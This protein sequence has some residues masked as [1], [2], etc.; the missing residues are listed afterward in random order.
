MAGHSRRFNPNLELLRQLIGRGH[1]GDVEQISAALGGR[2][3][4]WPQRTDFRRSRSLAGGG[5]LMDL[6]IHLIDLA[7]WLVDREASVE[8]YEASDVLSWGVE[9]D[10]EVTLRF[11][12]GAHAL[13]AC[14]YTH[15]L[16]RTLRVRGSHGWAETSVD[17]LPTVTFFSRRARV[18]QQR[19][20]QSFMIP[21]ADPYVRQLN[22]FVAAIIDEQPFSVDLDHV[23]AG[24]RVIQECYRVAQAA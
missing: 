15:G 6:G 8:R 19:G 11:D 24:L 9:S 4:A 20:A 1:L 16:N 22:H 5:V 3:G 14:S 18:C 21:E 7:L 10:A 2:Y 17:G 13:L 12:G 23:V